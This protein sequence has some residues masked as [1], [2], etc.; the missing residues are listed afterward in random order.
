MTPKQVVEAYLAE[1][2]GGQD[3]GSADELISS[4]ELLRRSLALRRAF[5]DL[6]VEPVLLLA[7]GGFVASHVLA[8][9]T[10]LGLFQGVPATGR[11][12]EARC[13]A[14]YRVERE[15]IA[16]GW[17]TWDYLALMEQLG[18]IERVSTVSA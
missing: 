16:E 4:D 18:A 9:G 8:R 17:V 5:P 2:L 1:V 13:T 11:A 3:V 7:E 12:W 15:R 14:V 6:Q 10:H